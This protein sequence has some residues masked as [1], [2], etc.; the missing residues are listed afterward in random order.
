MKD[1]G[2]SIPIGIPYDEAFLRGMGAG[3]NLAERFREIAPGVFLTGEVPR[4]TSFEV[5]VTG[6]YCDDSGCTPDPILDDQTLIIRGEKGL[7]LLFGCCHAGL[8][9]TIQYAME[10]TGT[11]EIYALVG[12]T[13][14]GYCPPAQL[15]NTI[16]FL[17]Q[18]GVR[19]I[20]CSHCTGFAASARLLREFP[21]QF[22]IA[23]VGY[24]LEV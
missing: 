8:V 9:N 17:R 21:R 23:Q 10:M 16:K 12:G 19:K 11:Q 13:H 18:C 4:K 14:L 22:Q 24:T 20:C 3:F 7:V 1:T 15:E 2:E 5:G 6:L